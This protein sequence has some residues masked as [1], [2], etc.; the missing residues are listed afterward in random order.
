MFQNPYRPTTGD[1]LIASTRVWKPPANATAQARPDFADDPAPT[2]PPPEPPPANPSAP[3]SDGQSRVLEQDPATNEK[4]RPILTYDEANF[5]QSCR[6]VSSTEATWRILSLPL[7]YFSHKINI[8]A[9]HLEGEN[10][11][12][13]KKGEAEEAARKELRPSTLTKYFD[14]VEE[15]R[16]LP[17]TD[18]NRKLLEEI[19]YCQVPEHF[20]WDGKERVWNRRQ[21]S[22]KPN[23]G[24]LAGAS[25]NSGD[26]FYL[27]LLLQEIPGCASFKELRTHDGTL[28]GTFKE[29]SVARGL[30]KDDEEYKRYIFT[31]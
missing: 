10:P 14:L 19:V 9:V 30:A 6:Y 21:K 17:D 16:Q 12:V 29:A 2:A 18:P 5:Y 1:L 28:Y 8:L 7:F 11:L 24:R 3:Y 15:S 25:P 22:N 20:L 4:L 27:R 23:L 13:F 31:N 26:R